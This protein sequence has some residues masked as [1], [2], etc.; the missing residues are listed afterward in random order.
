MSWETFLNILRETFSR[1]PEATSEKIHEGTSGK[2]VG[3]TSRKGPR[4]SFGRFFKEMVS[5]CFRLTIRK[6]SETS[7]R[8]R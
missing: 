8:N 6:I 7:A 1:T 4:G 5:L 2:T 3:R